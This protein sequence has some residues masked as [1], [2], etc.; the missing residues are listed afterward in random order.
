METVAFVLDRRV[1]SSRA[2]SDVMIHD[3][4]CASFVWSGR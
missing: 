1:S 2:L 4:D 3:V